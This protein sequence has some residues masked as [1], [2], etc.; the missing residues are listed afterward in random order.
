MPS[1]PYAKLLA[2]LNAGPPQS[3]AITTAA[4]GDTIQLSAEST[5]QWDLTVP[6][7]WEIYSYPPGWTGPA[8]GWD[9]ESVP[10]PFGG[11]AD[12][13]VYT[14]LGP[15]PSFTLPSAP[16]W[17]KFLLKLT[18]Q[19]G[20]MNGV[21]TTTLVDDAT[22][23]EI[24]SPIGLRDAATLEGTQFDTA[25][26]WSGP[27]QENLRTLETVIGTITVDIV[28]IETTL[29]SG[30]VSSV[31]ASAPITSS[32]GTTPTIGI[33]AAT[34]TD[35][36]SMSAA[37]FTLVN[38]ATASPTASTL[39]VR[40]GAGR[41]Q[42]ADPSASADIDTLGARD[43]AVGAV[44]SRVTVLEAPGNEYAWSPPRFAAASGAS[45]S[46]LSPGSSYTHGISFYVTKACDCV[47]LEGYWSV[48]GTETVRG[49]LWSPAGAS[50]ANASVLRSVSGI[51]TVTFG[52][53]V[54][55]TPYQLYHATQC[56]SGSNAMTTYAVGTTGI[57]L[58]ASP[59]Q[60]GHGVFIQGSSRQN[61][62]AN[63][64][65][66]AIGAQPFPVFPVLA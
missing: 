21:P 53:P 56:V 28:A 42:V 17:G 30:V 63:T 15:P 60:A 2:T 66:N 25:R 47:G 57:T 12:V 6:P 16:T 18:V 19:G 24:I 27:L 58:F 35:P 59:Y 37:H 26:A 29:S 52:S 3:G 10:Q 7:R 45:V 1:T 32:G 43:T 64:F 22:A 14:G 8:S 50:L 65:P 48:V 33:N 4:N 61:T 20:L 36:G 51:W 49:E 9:T 38:G 23:L 62:A 39:I 5:A 46:R 54:A 31:G 34:G 41:A 44:S 40:D 55:L 11:T 13:Y